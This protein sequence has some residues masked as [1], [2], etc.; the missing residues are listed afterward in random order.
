MHCS[1]TLA[2]LA[3][4]TVLLEACSPAPSDDLRDGGRTSL[5]ATLP[6]PDTALDTANDTTRDDID[7]PPTDTD[8]VPDAASD[9]IDTSAVDVDVDVDEQALNTVTIA[10]WNV[11]RFF[12]T[13][14]DSGSCNAND[15]ERAFSPAQMAFKARQVAD[16]LRRIDA[17]I[18]LIQEIESDAALEALDAELQGDWAVQVLGETFFDASVDVAVL[19][20]GELLGVERYR[21]RRIP[22]PGGGTTSFTREFL[23]VELS[24]RG[25]RVF[26]YTAHFKSKNDDDADRRLAEARA[27]AVIIRERVAEDPDALIV[28]G[29]DLNDEPG[30]PPLAALEADGRLLRVASD[31]DDASTYVFNGQGIAIDHLYLALDAAGSYVPRSAVVFREGLRGFAGS[32]HAA[33]RATFNLPSLP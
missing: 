21:D 1:R 18:V 13:V 8:T 19:A 22:R 12:D 20:R 29:G 2:S 26:V 16:G 6:P 11:A 3:V 32:D 7:P 28:L 25:R 23:E 31:L 27:A 24:I 5:D 17:D 33:L 10:T 4:L 15:Y 9:G 30:S 14:C